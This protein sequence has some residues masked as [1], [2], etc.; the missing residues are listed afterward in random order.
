MNTENSWPPTDKQIRSI[1]NSALNQSKKKD[2]IVC[3]YWDNPNLMIFDPFHFAN[4]DFISK[5]FKTKDRSVEVHI[6]RQD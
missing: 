3:V 4:T 6:G 5:K 1:A 2:I